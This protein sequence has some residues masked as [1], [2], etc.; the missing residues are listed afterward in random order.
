MSKKNQHAAVYG[1]VTLFR[2]TC[3]DCKGTA[4]IL[5]GLYQ[6]C[7]KPVEVK[8]KEFLRLSESIGKRHKPNKKTKEYLLAI[9]GNACLYCEKSFNSFTYRNYKPVK[10][11]LNW[12][13]LIPYSYNQN[14]WHENWC[15]ACHICN[16]IKSNKMFETIEECRNYINMIREKKGYTNSI[17]D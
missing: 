16:G 13:H 8:P 7:D 12:D 10:L 6:C 14:N 3:P 1:N 4:I 17:P 9:Q 11:K 5:E 2:G 15:A